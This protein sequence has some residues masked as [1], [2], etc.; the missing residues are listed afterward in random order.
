MGPVAVP[1]TL[2]TSMSERWNDH[3]NTWCQST[4][5]GIEVD[6]PPPCDPLYGHYFVHLQREIEGAVQL[7]LKR[8]SLHTKILHIAMVVIASPLDLGARAFNYPKHRVR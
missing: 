6:P 3:V 8:N 1:A 7:K 5:I 4:Q 2:I